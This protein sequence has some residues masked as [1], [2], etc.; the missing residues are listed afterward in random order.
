MRLKLTHKTKRFNSITETP[1]AIVDRINNGIQQ[2]E[3]LQ[4]RDR[5]E[6][7]ERRYSLF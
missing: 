1:K 2:L 7:K 4:R 6:R 3:K 5:E